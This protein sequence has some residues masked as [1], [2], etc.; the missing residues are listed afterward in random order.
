[1]NELRQEARDRNLPWSAV[2]AAYRD[3]KAAEWENRRVPNEVRS[4]AW[5][6]FTASRPGC[7]PFW[8]HGFLSRYGRRLARGADH[9][10]I[11]GYDEI[12]GQVAGS[13]PQYATPDGED[14]LWSFLLSP[15]DK[16]PDRHTLYQKALDLAE[17]CSTADTTSTEVEF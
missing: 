8:R 12:T 7:W 6:L 17:Q 13:F 14:R 5:M 1:M 15:Y 10:I 2:E 9:T 3:V 4:F 16:L 11:P